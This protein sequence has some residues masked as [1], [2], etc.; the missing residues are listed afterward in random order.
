MIAK[1][2]FSKVKKIV[3]KKEQEY[4]F[5]IS[6]FVDEKQLFMISSVEDLWC[7]EKKLL[8]LLKNKEFYEKNIIFS[9][10]DHDSAMKYL[11]SNDKSLRHGLT[12]ALKEVPFSE[13][14]SKVLASLVK[15]AKNKVLYERFVS[16]LITEISRELKMR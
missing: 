5:E 2:S 13:I 15:T 14:N 11:I 7:L 8:A 12:I 9:F 6:G 4:G 10:S 3:S 1:E 16:E